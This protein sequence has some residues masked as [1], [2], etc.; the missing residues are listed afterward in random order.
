[1][2][3]RLQAKQIDKLFKAPVYV[4]AYAYP[5]AASSNITAAMTA[6]FLTAANDG[7]AIPLQVNNTNPLDASGVITATGKNRVEVWASGLTT[8]G[9]TGTTDGTTATVTGVASTAGIVVGMKLV[10]AVGGIPV[11]ARVLSLVANTSVTF[12]SASNVVAAAAAFSVSTDPGEAKVISSSGAEVF[13]EVTEA[14]G[15]YTLALYS[16]ENS[17]KTLFTPTAATTI[18][19]AL[20]YLYTF[21]QLPADAFGGGTS[22]FISQDASG[23]DRTT[24]ERLTVTGTN[25][26]SAL[27]LPVKSGTVSK[28]SINGQVL[29]SL[30]GIN[31]PFSIVSTAVTWNSVKAGFSLVPGIDVVDV[32][33]KY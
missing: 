32:E 13:G 14:A 16:I 10:T 3:I 30:G 31:A 6:A 33:Y 27:S 19:L 21:D 1:M 28:L 23:G 11:G 9:F 26:L 8:V 22:K 15:V 17:V 25:V 29:S 2:T 4:S 18:D 12:D 7:T 24:V 20:P 5:A